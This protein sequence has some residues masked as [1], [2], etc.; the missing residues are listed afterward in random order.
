MLSS[1]IKD[2]LRQPRPAACALLGNCHKHGMPSSHSAVM[3]FAATTALLLYLHRAEAA[4]AA[5]GAGKK[6]RSGAGGRS[7]GAA[8]LAD[9]L[10]RF[11]ELLEV[12]GLLALTAAVAYGRV[13]LQYHS[14]EQVLAGLALGAAAALAW[15][16]VTLAA[17]T[18]RWAPTLL[19]LA[20][21]RALSMRNTLGVPDV[22]ASEAALFGSPAGGGSGAS[23]RGSPKAARRRRSWWPLG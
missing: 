15:W 4:A 2:A 21:L 20:P 19:R 11:F 13:Y 23:P 12:Q 7:G 16:R 5:A 17:C 6:R 14:P 1:L 9:R 22:H 8:S 18:G 10:A 3:A